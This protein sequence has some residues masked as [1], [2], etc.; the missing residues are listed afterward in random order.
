MHSCVQDFQAF[1]FFF[2]L[3]FAVSLGLL[4][5]PF[6]IQQ[7]FNMNFTIAATY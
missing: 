6:V 3:F 5:R 2:S 1:A 7:Y 4:S